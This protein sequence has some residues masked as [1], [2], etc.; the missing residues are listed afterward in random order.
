MRF[1][2]LP[3]GLWPFDFP[4]KHCLAQYSA[5]ALIWRS[6]ING[7]EPCLARNELC[8][9]RAPFSNFD[10]FVGGPE[11]SSQNLNRGPLD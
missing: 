8:S 3:L 7:P 4:A 11:I 2:P 10:I 5:L 9:S 1:S 6:R